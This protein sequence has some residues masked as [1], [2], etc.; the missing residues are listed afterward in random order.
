MA[1]ALD[2]SRIEVVGLDADDTLWA[3]EMIFR[4]AEAEIAR[5]L[6]A[7]EVP[8][9]LQREMYAIETRNLAAYGYGIKGFV[10]SMVEL[11]VRTSEGQV[12]NET[13][14]RILAIGREMLAAPVEVL[15]GVHEALEALRARYR[16]VVITKGDLLDQNRKLA[17]SGLL[18]YFH[19]TEVVSDKRTEDYAEVLRRLD[20]RGEAFLMV[21][22]SLKSDVLP[23]LP[24]GAQAVHV[25]YHVTWE[26]ERAE[27]D[28]HQ[29]YVELA[30][31]GQ[32]VGLLG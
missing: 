24:L 32:L 18:A 26:H 14:E 6:A 9:V 25:P 10:L 19:H 4:D 15:P 20:L 31:L 8:H 7:Y 1:H 13:I 23:V 12:A 5:L 3:N 28:E 21:G 29:A 16:L 2:P 30:D 27:A 17:R 22:N 11:A